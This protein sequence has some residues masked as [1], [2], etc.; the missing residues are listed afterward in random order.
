MGI[1]WRFVD[2]LN[3]AL[4]KEWDNREYD[5]TDAVDKVRWASSRYPYL[6][7]AFIETVCKEQ[8]KEYKK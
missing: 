4:P 5:C 7:E 2:R 1:D 3:E 8:G 6:L